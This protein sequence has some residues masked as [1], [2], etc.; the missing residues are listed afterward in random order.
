MNSSLQQLFALPELR[1]AI[2]HDTLLPAE[3]EGSEGIRVRIKNKSKF[4]ADIKVSVRLVS[5]SPEEYHGI[6][7]LQV[8]AYYSDLSIARHVYQSCSDLSPRSS[9][10]LAWGTSPGGRR[11]R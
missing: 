7:S 3:H 8:S 2:T 9:C 6:N 11:R 1:Q 10:A 5:V 4:L